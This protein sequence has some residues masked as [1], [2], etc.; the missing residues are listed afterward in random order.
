MTM[1]TADFLP[2]TAFPLMKFAT[3]LIADFASAL[4]SLHTA[5]R[6]HGL[7]FVQFQHWLGLQVVLNQPTAVLIFSVE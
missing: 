5:S 7:F 3:V 1:H 6:P 2:L 4:A